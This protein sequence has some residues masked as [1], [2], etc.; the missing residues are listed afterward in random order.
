M[1]RDAAFI[2][3]APALE[4]AA[5]GEATAVLLDG[6]GGVGVS[7]FVGEVAR[8]VGGLSEP[9]IVVRGRSYRPGADD[10]YGPIVR[11]LR[12]IF[13]DVDDDELVR[14]VGPAVEDVARLFPEIQARLGHAGVLPAQPTIIAPER[15]QGR[16]LEAIL[17]RRRAAVRG[18]PGAR[19]PRGPPRCRRRH[20]RPRHVPEPGPPPPSGLLHRHLGVRRADAGPSAQRHAGRGDRRAIVSRP[21]RIRIEPFERSELA[22]L[23]QAIEGERPTGAALVLVADRSR[24][25]PLVAEELLAARREVSDASL[26][27]SFDDL[28]IARLARRGPECRRVLRLLAL[29]GRPVDRD[30]LADIAGDVRD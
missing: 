22:D 16:V 10:P 30:E 2:R 28:V 8:R 23:V 5:G 14:L 27:S 19:R 4:A 21:L 1:G 11:A 6:P 29:S 20:P 3:L 12:P 25:L 18:R 13:R 15:R 9:F 7:R 26:T 17:G 24:G